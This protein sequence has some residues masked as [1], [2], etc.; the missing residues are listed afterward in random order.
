MGL[1]HGGKFWIH[2]ADWQFGQNVNADAVDFL[3]PVNANLLTPLAGESFALTTLLYTHQIGGGYVAAVG[4]VNCLDFWDICYP[5]YGRGVDG[6]MNVSL[7]LPMNAIPSVP[8]IYNTACLLKES[9]R[10]IEAAL[11]AIE[12]HYVPEMVGLDFPNG[13]TIAGLARKFT[14]FGG[15]PGS[16]MLLVTYATGEYALV[17]TEGLGHCA[18]RQRRSPGRIR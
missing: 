4:R 7:N 3:A 12:S 16:H 18:R 1:W 5:D 2:A 15:L 10:G 11:F 6:F 14:D 9:K 13:L 17:D 8:F